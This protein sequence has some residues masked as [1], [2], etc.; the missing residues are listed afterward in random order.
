MLSLH[1]KSKPCP[2]SIS[3]SE[4][5]EM[6]KGSALRVIRMIK[7]DP[8]TMCVLLLVG[9]FLL[10][11]LFGHLYAQNCAAAAEDA[12]R[13]YLSDCCIWFEQAGVN[14][15]IGRTILLYFGVVCVTFLFRFSALGMVAIPLFSVGIGFTSFY[16]VSCFVQSFGRVGVVLAAALT[17]TRLLFTLPCFIVVAGEALPNSFRLAVLMVGRGKRIGQVSDGGRCMVIF[18]VC[19][20]CLCI[21]VL[22]ER[23]LTPILFRAVID[24]LKPFPW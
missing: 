21:G 13:R 15:P 22:C 11:G 17:A 4:V 12:F 19:F 23:L 20:I 18:V 14:I 3:L 2:R 10:G 7:P 5:M 24:R 1:P 9:C 16:T 8:M 6:R